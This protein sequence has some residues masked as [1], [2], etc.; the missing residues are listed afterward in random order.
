[1]Q[2]KFYVTKET[3]QSSHWLAEKSE[4]FQKF[5]KNLIGRFDFRP[6]LQILF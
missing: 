3:A 2:V 5:S 4:K 1:M 6:L